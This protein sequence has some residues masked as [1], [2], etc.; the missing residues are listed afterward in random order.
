MSVD[1]LAQDGD[2]VASGQ[3]H[4]EQHERRLLARCARQRAVAIGDRLDRIALTGEP[5]R[6]EAGNAALVLDDQDVH[7]DQTPSVFHY[8]PLPP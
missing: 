3:H 4:V 8:S 6:H 1:E 5:A 7:E 2:A